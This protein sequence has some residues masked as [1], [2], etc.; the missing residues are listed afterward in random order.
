MKRA[1]NYIHYAARSVLSDKLYSTFYIL[2]TAVAFVLIILLLSAVRLISS[3]ARPFVNAENT[4]HIDPYFNDAQ[5]KFIGGIAT[6]DIG[7]FVESVPGAVGYSISNIQY[8]IAFAN[9]KVRSAA[10]SFVDSRYFEVND[11]EFISGRPFTDATANQAVLLKS[12][13]DRCYA[14]DPVG[15]TI[16]IQK[17]DYRIVGVV[18]D[19]ST[20]QNPEEVAVMWVPYT[21]DKFIP[22]GGA[23]FFDIDIV[24]EKG[25]PVGEMKDNLKHSLQQYFS[26][27]SDAG[28]QVK[29][30][31]LYTLQ[32][33]KYDYAGGRVFGYGAAVVLFLL[34]LI[35]ALNI[36]TLSSAKVQSLSREIAI[37]RALGASSREAFSQIISENILLTLIGFVF[38]AFLAE[39]TLSGIDSLLF[40]DDSISSILSGFQFNAGVY[41]AAFFMA[42]LFALIAGGIPAYNI[43]RRNIANELKGRD[44]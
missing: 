41:M 31:D 43:S 32:E 8:T 9:E 33:K 23:Q 30:T 39:P 38:A 26:K 15:E 1:L 10:V 14:G 7:P 40:K 18:D 21:F 13:A 28:V 37:R 22:S 5:G 44:L 27:Q 2:G 35:P 24:F 20:L 17:N 4:I 12:F 42:M 29:P 19:F 3:D 34:L 16:T 11:F 25:M 36:M 6:Q